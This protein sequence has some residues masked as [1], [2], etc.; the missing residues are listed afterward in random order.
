VAATLLAATELDRD[1]EA[2]PR[3]SRLP[4][5]RLEPGTTL[6]VYRIESIIGEGGMGVVYRAHDQALDRAVA[7]KCLHTNLA[8]DSQIRRRFAREARVL[9]EWTHPN[10]VSIFDFVEQE[11]LLAIVMEYIEG[12][13]LVQ[14]LASWR[15]RM[16]W[17]EIGAVFGAVLDTMDDGHRV[18]VVHRD[19][20][21]DNILVYTASDGGLRP[22]I[23]D[24]GIS[25]ILEGTSYTMSG[26]FL[27][28]CR[29]MSPEQV[30]NPNT[31]DYRSDI[32]SLGI[33]LYQ[34]CTG[35]VPFDDGNHFAVMM[36]HVNEA[37][38][39][40][41]QLRGDIPPALERLVLDALSKDPAA[42]PQTCA[43]FRARL[44]QA[45][46]GTAPSTATIASRPPPAPSIQDTGGHEMILVPGGPFLMGPSR[47]TV[48]VDAFYMDRT[49]VTNEQFDRFV[50]VT[51]YRPPDPNV[52]RFLHHVPSGRTPSRFAKCPVVYVSWADAKAYATW[53]G[54]RLPTE[55]EWEKAARGTDG[56]KYPWGRAEPTALRASFGKACSEPLP[57]G[58]FPEGA[59][60][61]GILDMAGNV[62]EWCDDY[63]DPRF[64]EDGP[65][66]N[67]RNTKKV[68]KPLVV[69][70]GGSFLFG[71]RALRTY[72]RTSYDPEVRFA[73]GGFRCVREVG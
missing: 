43:I 55:A 32:Y 57:V 2:S 46:E 26:A 13:S 14:H 20:K 52:G 54:K 41:S 72:S 39:P 48:H 24:F 47:R 66:H 51:G 36:A 38:R 8:G 16:P 65:S 53:A 10:V 3:A 21:P 42:R 31:A 37:P 25:K 68:A 33:S 19:L 6:S 49:P 1:P 59:S 61:Y 40:P 69:M 9:R 44:D 34:L 11:H 28:T 17:S 18:G 5:M 29:Y 56:R 60:P 35:D 70:R 45:L 64:Y 4:P 27:G 50:R 73:S 30:R 58:S 7:I 67:P 22:K 15:G 12:K 62:W 23:V 63:D 71:P